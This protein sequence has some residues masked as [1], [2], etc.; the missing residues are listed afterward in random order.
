MKWLLLI[1]V[2]SHNGG[3]DITQVRNYPDKGICQ[4]AGRLVADNFKNA[5]HVDIACIPQT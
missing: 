2:F 3:V 5:V 1:A 4:I